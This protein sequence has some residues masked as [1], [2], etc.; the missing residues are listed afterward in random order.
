MRIFGEE[1]VRQRQKD[2][3]TEKDGDTERKTGRI[4]HQDK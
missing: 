2:T 1:W 4:E 3:E